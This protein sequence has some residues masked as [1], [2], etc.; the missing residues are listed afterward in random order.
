MLGIFGLKG[1]GKTSLLHILAGV[2]RFKKGTVYILG[3]DIKKEQ[4]FKKN[5]GIVTQEKSLFHDLTAIENLDFI[6]TLKETGTGNIE[7]LVE[8]LE[9]KEYLSE[10]AKHL[11]PGIYQRLS[12][13]CALLNTPE[14]LI[15]DEIVKDIDLYSRYLI[16]KELQQFKAGG[17]TCIYS[18][19][20]IEFCKYMDRVIYLEH[21]KITN[22]EPEEFEEKWKKTLREFSEASGGKYE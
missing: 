19:S 12:L 6:S 20:N 16:L 17:G 21:G 5:I 1:T 15:I 9:L 7:V 2:D 13:A 10:P 4:G 3:C 22:F 11:D 18:F 8:K 14:L